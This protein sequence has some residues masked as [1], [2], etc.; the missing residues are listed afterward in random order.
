MDATTLAM[1]DR[2]LELLQAAKERLQPEPEPELE[3]NE[4][5]LVP[6]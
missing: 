2:A 6:W 5:D 4:T 3:P 1:I